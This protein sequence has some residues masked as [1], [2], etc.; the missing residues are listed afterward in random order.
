M[1]ES[2]K[3]LLIELEAIVGNEFYNANI[4][5]WGP[6]GT[7]EGKGRDFRYPINFLG[8][9]GKKLKVK[10]VDP[11]L[12]PDVVI[13]GSYKVGANELYIMRALEKVLSHLERDH[14]FVLGGK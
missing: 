1:E 4:Q 8:K 7:F 2:R 9:D 3:R 6:G 5:N 13:T 11:S 10:R 12:P 14:G